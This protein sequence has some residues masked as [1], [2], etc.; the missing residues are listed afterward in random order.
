[1]P[2]ISIDETKQSSRAGWSV[3][4]GRTYSLQVRVVTNDVNIGAR[5]A[6][7]ACNVDVGSPYRFPLV[8]PTEWDFGS[9]L[10]GISAEKE[11]EDGL[12]YLVTMDFGQFKATEEAGAQEDN[13]FV[14]NPL[15]APPTVRW[16]SETYEVACTHTRDG[17]LIANVNK[18]PFDPPLARPQT[19]P[20]A[21]VTRTLAFFDPAWI[22]NYQGCINGLDWQGFPA[23]TVMLKEIA[24][25]KTF[26]TDFGWLWEQTLVFACKP[27]RYAE[28]GTTLIE[29]GWAE[30]VLNTGLREKKAGKIKQVIIDG[31]PVSSPVALTSKGEYD[32]D[33]DDQGYLIFDILPTLDYSVLGLP[34]NL[35]SITGGV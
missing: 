12:S 9:T 2:I 8:E 17:K 23:G 16:S 22:A 25:D 26:S 35:F 31:S 10:T 11:A 24:A 32:P 5:A 30:M 14:V 6:M 20:L 13:T 27:I 18:D 28:D 1:M 33:S 7:L 15:N 3:D 21:T 29:A 19:I 4:G 34:D